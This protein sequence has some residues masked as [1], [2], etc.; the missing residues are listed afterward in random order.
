MGDQ[1]R[2]GADRVARF[3]AALPARVDELKHAWRAWRENPADAH[4]LREYRGLV[5]R[6]AG[7]ASANGVAEIGRRAQH[8]D[9]QLSAWQDEEPSLRLPLADLVATVEPA[10]QALLG[11]LDDA[12]RNGVASA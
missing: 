5:H 3:R 12:A 1:R 6:L 9:A 7:S 10:A 2:G 8:V 4:A 11:A